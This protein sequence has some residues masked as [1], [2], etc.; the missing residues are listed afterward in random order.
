[1]IGYYLSGSLSLGG[2]GGFFF[3]LI[4]Y[5]YSALLCIFLIFQSYGEPES[6]YTGSLTNYD[7]LKQ[8]TN[9]KANPLVREITFENG[10]EL[11]EE[12]LPFL[13]LFYKAGDVTSIQRFKTA[14]MRE[15]IPDRSN[16]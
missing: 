11:T 10:E 3:K 12:G 15:L 8:W 2:G 5:G 6:T 1:M 13:L 16:Y 14:V 7:L 4:K 9:D